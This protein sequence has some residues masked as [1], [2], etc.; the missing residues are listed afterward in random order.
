MGHFLTRLPFQLPKI[1]LHLHQIGAALRVEVAHDV[2]Q[3]QGQLTLLLGFA[4]IDHSFDAPQDV[5]RIGTSI[6]IA[7]KL[8]LERA[9]VRRA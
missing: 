7:A 9:E 8:L 2:G 5:V 1:L 3:P 6:Q 4:L